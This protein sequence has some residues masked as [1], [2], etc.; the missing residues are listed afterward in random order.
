MTETN[1][2]PSILTRCSWA[3]STPRYMTYHDEEW[4]VPLHGDRELYER[5]ALEGFQAGLSW[6]TILNKRDRFREVFAS[7]DPEVVASFDETDVERLMADAGII[8]NRQKI[9]AAIHNAR[10]VLE[11][12]PGEFDDLLWSFAPEA[13]PLPETE[14][15]VPSTSPESIAMSKE[16][17][18]RGFKFVGPTTMYALMQSTGMVDDHVASCWRARE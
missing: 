10:L 16:L 5:V 13:G 2:T 6:I 7:F 12:Q 9:M 4:G 1:V 18:R 17:R 14:A 3:N 8:R 15:D 11:M